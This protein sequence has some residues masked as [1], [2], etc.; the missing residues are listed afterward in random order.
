VVPDLPGFPLPKVGALTGPDEIGISLEEL[1]LDLTGNTPSPSRLAVLRQL[2]G[3]GASARRLEAYVFST[4]EFYRNSGGTPEGFLRAL[5]HDVFGKPLAA[6]LT[7]DLARL[8]SGVSR[9]RIIRDL[10]RL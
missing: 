2:A 5:Y 1:F 3:Q 4:P 7:R 6:K 8:H 9:T 10:L